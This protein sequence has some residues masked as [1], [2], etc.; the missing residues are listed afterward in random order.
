MH[1][2]LFKFL[3]SGDSMRNILNVIDS[4]QR[5]LDDWPMVYSGL[6]QCIQSINYNE[7]CVSYRRQISNDRLV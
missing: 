7:A 1:I 5:H 6:L 2:A 3:V 4:Q